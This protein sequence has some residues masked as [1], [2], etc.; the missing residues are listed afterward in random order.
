MHRNRQE[1]DKYNIDEDICKTQE[2]NKYNINEYICKIQE[3]KDYICNDLLSVIN[4]YQENRNIDDLITTLKWIRENVL[5]EDSFQ[6]FI[7]VLSYACRNEWLQ[8]I[9]VLYNDDN[10]DDIFIGC[11]S[12]ECNACNTVIYKHTKDLH[13]FREKLHTFRENLLLIEHYNNIYLIKL[14]TITMYK[15]FIKEIII[16]QFNDISITSDL[17]LIQELMSICENKIY[18]NIKKEVIEIFEYACDNNWKELMLVLYGE[19]LHG[20]VCKCG[21]RVNEHEYIS[22]FGNADEG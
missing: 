12:N 13:T 11:Y 8:F 18:I 15:D 1:E 6:I 20:V 4:E 19:Y 5:I 2:E 10:C 14:D 3:E 16:K 21:K 7:D 22:K 17:D 9:H